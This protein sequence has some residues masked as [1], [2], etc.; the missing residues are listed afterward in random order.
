[1]RTYRDVLRSTTSLRDVYGDVHMV[2]EE[3]WYVIG[4]DKTLS[5]WGGAE[6]KISKRVVICEDFQQAQRVAENMR[7]D[8]F[9]YVSCKKAKWG[10]PYF[11]PSRYRVSINHVKDCPIWNK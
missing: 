10:F 2:T 9:I 1:M 4:N 7:K 5:Y 6:G 11:S 8:K 3:M